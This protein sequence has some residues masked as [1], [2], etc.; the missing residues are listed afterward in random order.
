[1]SEPRTTTRDPF[2]YYRKLQRVKEHVENNLAADLSLEKAAAVAGLQKKYFS[3]FFHERTGVRYR[4]WVS[5][6]RVRAAQVML[7]N[8]NHSITH[9]AFAVGFRDVRTF[10]R[11]FKKHSSMTPN[12]YK[13]SVEPIP[14]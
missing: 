3:T 7:S 8:A 10:E 1:M 6:L 14:R 13:R 2:R 4:D 5:S 9:V 11:A 12:A